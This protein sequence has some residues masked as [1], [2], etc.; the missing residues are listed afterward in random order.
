MRDIRWTVV[1]PYFNEAAFLPD[2]L[3]SLAGQTLRPFRVVLV[4][5]GSTDAGPSHVRDWADAQ[6][7]IEVLLLDEAVPGQVHA[8]ARGITAVKTEF[9]AICDADT[10]YP[11]DYLAKADAHLVAAGAN[12]VGYIAHN[13]RGHA[14]SFAERSKR[15][16]Y[17]AVIPHILRNQAHGGGYA[18]LMRTDLFRASGGYSAALWPYVLKD[19]ELAHRLMKQGQIRYATDLW[20]EPSTRRANRK[21]VRWTLWERLVYHASPP[22]AKDWF[23]YNFMRPRFDARGQKDIVLRAQP[24]TDE[25]SSA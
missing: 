10:R 11:P 14:D 8:L 6:T 17:S 21:G 15:W 20:V 22:G 25:K 24:W 4:N 13:S 5:N 1:I 9:L 12:V 2:T 3:L 19:H 23:W 16:L 18:H 7:G